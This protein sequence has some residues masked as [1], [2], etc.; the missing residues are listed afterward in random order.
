MVA[1]PNSRLTAA[2]AGGKFDQDPD[3][4]GFLELVDSG[5]LQ[6]NEPLTLTKEL[7]GGGAG[8]MASK[9]VES[10]FP[11][12]EVATEMIRVSDN[13]AT[14]LLIEQAGGQGPSTPAS[15]PLDC[16]RQRSTTGCQISMAPTP[17]APAISVAPSRWWTA[18]K[19][20]APG[21][22]S[23]PRSDVDVGDG[24]TPSQQACCRAL[25]AP[26]VRRMKAWLARATTFTTKPV[27]SGLPTPT[28]G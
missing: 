8:W 1:L 24:H 3:S 25:V 7:I 5:D 20:S 15:R 6:W 28:Q 27:T 9:P 10:R 18:V 17:P 2:D 14:N 13:S 21:A 4:A 23:L 19:P 26:R 12:F 11:T 16:L 22:G